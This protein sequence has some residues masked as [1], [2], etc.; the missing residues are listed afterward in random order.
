MQYRHL[1]FEKKNNRHTITEA[2][3]PTSKTR[4]WVG[5][6]MGQYQT[7]KHV[8]AILFLT[9]TKILDLKR[10][11]RAFTFRGFLITETGETKETKRDNLRY[12]AGLGTNDR[13]GIITAVWGVSG[14]DRQEHTVQILKY[15]ITDT[16][17]RLDKFSILIYNSK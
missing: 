13:G 15:K 17:E 4:H 5:I 10:I 7:E 12:L 6:M 1:S 3:A 9:T 8:A 2:W 11:K 16:S 14:T